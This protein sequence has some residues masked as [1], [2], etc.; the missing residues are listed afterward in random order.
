MV[1]WPVCLHCRSLVESGAYGLVSIEAA[2]IAEELII[3]D[4]PIEGSAYDK[5]AVVSC[6]RPVT[7]G[8]RPGCLDPRIQS[9]QEK[10]PVRTF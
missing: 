4:G 3:S 1:W 7:G 2:W 5:H 10:R 6:S 8:V 9:I